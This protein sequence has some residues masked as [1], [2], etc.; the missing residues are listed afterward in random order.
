MPNNILQVLQM[1]KDP[2]V[3]IENMLKQNSN[4]ILINLVQMAQKGDKD[5]LENFARNLFK[6]QGQDFDKLYSQLI[7]RK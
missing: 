5:G 4:P 3:Y 6:S 1:I 7:P 2:K